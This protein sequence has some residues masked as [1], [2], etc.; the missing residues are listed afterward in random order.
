MQTSKYHFELYSRDGTLLAD[1]TGRAKNRRI[2]QSRNHPEEIQWQ[3]NLDE[4][5]RYCE[6]LGA[7]PNEILKTNSTEV[8]IRRGTKYLCGGQITYVHPRANATSQDIEIR[9]T[10]FLNLFQHRY[11]DELH[12]FPPGTQ[13][14]QIPADL[15]EWT[16][17]RGPNWDFGVTIGSLATVGTHEKTFKAVQVK[18]ALQRCTELYGFDFEFTHDKVF[19]T[20]AALGSQRPELIF[21]Y[22]GNVLDIGKPTDGTDL[23]NYVT[24]SGSGT[25]EE[26]AARV[27]IDETDPTVGV[28]AGLSMADHRVQEKRISYSDV[29]DETDLRKHGVAHVQAWAVP[30]TIP[31]I[32][33]DGNTAPFVTDYGIGDWVTARA[34]KYRLFEEING[35]YRLEKRTIAIDDQDKETVTLELSDQ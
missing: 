6:L 22:P 12:Y 21:E 28:V 7:D 14:T 32:V 24:V 27:V 33:V 20:Y 1:L 15:I 16:Q 29:E 25:G 31:D 30:F 5:E 23:A 8:R 11:T 19:N 18:E 4:F 9:A 35:L 10:G 3:V 13:A 26:S 17:G 2:V 34:R